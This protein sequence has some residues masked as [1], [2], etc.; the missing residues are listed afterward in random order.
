M[1]MVAVVD[2][3]MEEKMGEVEEEVEVE[4]QQQ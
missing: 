3:K 1:E 2:K 4:K